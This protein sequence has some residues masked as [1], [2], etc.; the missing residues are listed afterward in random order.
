MKMDSRVVQ[1]HAPWRAGEDCFL[2]QML[3]AAGRI[4]PSLWSKSSPL[5]AVLCVNVWVGRLIVTRFVV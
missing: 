4:K 5:L 1:V 2:L 3:I